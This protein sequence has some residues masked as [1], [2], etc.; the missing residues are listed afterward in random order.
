MNRINRRALVSVLAGVGL[1]AVGGAMLSSPASAEWVKTGQGTYDV[2]GDGVRDYWE[3]YTDEDTGDTAMWYQ[4]DDGWHVIG[5]PGPDGAS[6]GVDPH[7]LDDAVAQ[8]KNGAGGDLVDG[9]SF[10]ASPAG[11]S[12][13]AGGDGPAPVW[14]PGDGSEG[15]GQPSPNAGIDEQVTID[16]G[17]ATGPGGGIQEDSGSPASQLKDGPKP[18]G[19]GSG[20]VYS[21]GGGSDDQVDSGGTTSDDPWWTSEQA[22]PAVNPNPQEKSAEGASGEPIVAGR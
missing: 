14:N 11:E 6:P 4:L 22:A 2:D 7:G 12:A 13:E 9:R 3:E 19:P 15:G 21:G 1:S 10:W 5:D 16:F 17:G 20:T 8:A 18:T